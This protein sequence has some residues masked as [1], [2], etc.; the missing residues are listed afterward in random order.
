MNRRTRKLMWFY[1]LSAGV[2][3]AVLVY[4]NIA[5]RNQQIQDI[6]LEQVASPLL[7]AVRA[8]GMWAHELIAAVHHHEQAF[9]ENKQLRK[10]VADLKTWRDE[11]LFL[12]FENRHLRAMVNMV[13]QQKVKPVSGH[14]LAD[15]R[16][17]YAQSMLIDIGSNKG[18]AGGQA[19]LGPNGLVGRVLDVGPDVSRVLLLTD[20]NARIPVLLQTSGERGILRGGNGNLLELILTD[21]KVKPQPGERVVTSFAGGVLQPGLPVGIVERV[22][23]SVW[24]QPFTDFN[25]LSYVT[26]QLARP[27][28]MTLP[29]APAPQP[30]AKGHR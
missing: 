7:Y 1:G 4:G 20:H 5:L 16:S 12:R 2:A 27:A 18:V 29:A 22:D 3:L 28:D 19:V 6:W 30:R 24:V 17:S 25:A 8:P 13:S 11:A 9:T 26:V 14:V 21:S 15:S 23:D 10:Q